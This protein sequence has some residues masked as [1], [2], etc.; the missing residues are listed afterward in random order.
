[1]FQK[2]VFIIALLA[3]AA[4]G[5]AAC[6]PDEQAETPFAAPPENG[7]PE[8]GE[9]ILPGTPP[10]DPLASPAA[11][12]AQL[13]NLGEAI[14]NEQCTFCHQQDGSGMQGVYPA[15][16]GSLFVTGDPIPVIE[17]V[18]HGRGGMPAFAGIL[19]DEETAGV[20]S[21]IRRA[22]S[23]QAAFVTIEQVQAAR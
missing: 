7:I 9:E 14:Y 3:V 22:W 8:T 19:A 15:L 21:F 16:D 23:N 5:M 20:V 4:F 13:L 18:L 12:G 17:I 6:A 1:M 2:P 10:G 11:G